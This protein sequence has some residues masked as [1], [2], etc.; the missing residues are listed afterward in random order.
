MT[1]IA[2]VIAIKHPKSKITEQENHSINSIYNIEYPT[3]QNTVT[4]YKNNGDY[5]QQGPILLP[6]LIFVT[7]MK[8]M[9]D[10]IKD[11]I[12]EQEN[13]VQ[14][15]KLLPGIEKTIIVCGNDAGV[16]ELCGKYDIIN[17]ITTET[18]FGIPL[19][20]SMMK[21]AYKYGSDR[22][23]YIWINAD[24]ILLS[25]FVDLIKNFIQQYP[26]Y[27][28]LKYGMTSRRYNWDNPSSIDYTD[29]QW[30]QNLLGMMTNMKLEAPTAMDIFIH[31]YKAFDD[32]PD[33]AIARFGHDTWMLN[34]MVTSFDLAINATDSIKIIHHMSP[35]LSGDGKLLDRKNNKDSTVMHQDPGAIWNSN[36]RG[37]YS[38]YTTANDCQI[39]TTKH[40]NTI[41]FKKR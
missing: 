5:T 41:I 16:A 13:S 36:T 3:R 25:D 29:N 39:A 15:W 28:Q 23:I 22:D 33:F 2:L 38:R 30:E 24:I 19:V 12:I 7:T 8:Q 11:F 37:G 9:T 1:I 20:S 10:E 17:D 21:T 6:K 32:M 35:W 14:S 26:N 4:E 27:H 34:K 31:G 18:K 40:G